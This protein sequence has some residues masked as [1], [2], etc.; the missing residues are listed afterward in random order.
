MNKVIDL[1]GLI[2]RIFLIVF[3]FVF[4]QVAVISVFRFA[5]LD[6]NIYEGLFS[7]VYGLTA[8]A[9][10]LLYGFVRSIKSDRLIRTDKPD[11]ISIIAAVVIAF[12]LLGLVTLYMYAAVLISKNFE[13]LADQLTEYSDSVDRFATVDGSKVPYWDT[14]LEFVSSFMIIPLAEELTFRGALYSEL[15]TRVKAIPAAILSALVFGLMHGI[16]IHV[17][18]A[19]ICGFVLALVYHFSGSIWVSY[20][21][22]SVFNLMGSSLFTL[23]DSG[24]YG[25]LKNASANA[26]V[27]AAVLE[28]ICIIPAVS[29]LVIMY[30]IYKDRQTAIPEVHAEELA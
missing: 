26:S 19:F 17:G 18:Y 12:G 22:H 10:M 5:G 11:G 3:L 4:I 8:V 9:V 25:D 27:H 21:V 1:L 24:I 14:L 7:T 2:F 23:L 6:V 30:L 20:I 29:A 16:S 13:P 28:I 15:N